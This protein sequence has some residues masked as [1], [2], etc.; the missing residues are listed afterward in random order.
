MVAL[1][2]LVAPLQGNNFPTQLGSQLVVALEHHKNKT[3]WFLRLAGNRCVAVVVMHM[4]TV[5]CRR[6]GWLLELG[7][8]DDGDACAGPFGPRTA[9]CWALR[10]VRTDSRGCSSAYLPRCSQ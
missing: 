1:T 4:L 5:S 6:G 9:R 2:P 7:G 3:L 10:C 8:D